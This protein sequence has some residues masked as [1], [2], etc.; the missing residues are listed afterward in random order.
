MTLAMMVLA[1][2]FLVLSVVYMATGQVRTELA[3]SVRILL[4][5]FIQLVGVV[6]AVL[7]VI[8]WLVTS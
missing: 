4:A 3:Q 8:Q 2:A 7:A 6:L 1:I 5:I